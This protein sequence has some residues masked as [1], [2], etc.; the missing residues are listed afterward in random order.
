MIES[1]I[2]GLWLMIGW[3]D[4]LWF[5]CSEPRR[6]IIPWNTRPVNSANKQTHHF[7]FS[8]NI[9]FDVNT[10]CA[11]KKQTCGNLSN[12]FFD[13]LQTLSSNFSKDA[14]IAFWLSSF[15]S[16]QVNKSSE[17]IEQSFDFWYEQIPISWKSTGLINWQVFLA[18]LHDQ[19]AL[20]SNKGSSERQQD[21]LF[22]AGL[23]MARN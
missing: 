16:W 22:L 7:L 13:Q 9:I 1:M 17:I 4:G 19:L 14:M 8:S 23:G 21:V 11:R 3:I 18:R 2:D 20:F 12:D 15:N 5:S 6:T 10:F